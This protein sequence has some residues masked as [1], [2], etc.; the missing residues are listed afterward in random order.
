MNLGEQFH[1]ISGNCGF[2]GC[3][4]LDLGEQFHPVSGNCGC[5]GD[6]GWGGGTGEWKT[7]DGLNCDLDNNVIDSKVVICLLTLS[8][9]SSFKQGSTEETTTG[10]ST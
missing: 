6:G 5:V 7:S 10:F 2:E 4:R 8:F 1:P 9:G 3:R